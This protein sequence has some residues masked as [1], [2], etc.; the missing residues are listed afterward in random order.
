MPYL[1]ASRREAS[2][3]V[4]ARRQLVWAFSVYL[5]LSS[6]SYQ[7][8]ATHRARPEVFCLLIHGPDFWV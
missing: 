1:V 4:R 2:A 6:R 8:E 5:G 3:E 7:E